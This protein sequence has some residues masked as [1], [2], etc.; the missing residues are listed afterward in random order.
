MDILAYGGI[1]RSVNVRNFKDDIAVLKLDTMLEMVEMT[2]ELHKFEADSKVITEGVD[3]IDLDLLYMEAEEKTSKQRKSILDSAYD[4][5]KNLFHKI[6][7]MFRSL[8]GVKKDVPPSKNIVVPDRY[9]ADKNIIKALKSMVAGIP[10][11]I[12]SHKVLASAALAIG[13]A[14]GTIIAIVKSKKA[15]DAKVMKASQVQAEVIQPLSEINKSLE[16]FNDELMK[17][18]VDIIDKDGSVIDSNKQEVKVKTEKPNESNED[19]KP[20]EEKPTTESVEGVGDIGKYLKMTA[21][22]L[23]S[24]ITSKLTFLLTKIKGILDYINGVFLKVTGSDAS[25]YNGDDESPEKE[26]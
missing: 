25:E 18:D 20:S 19:N 7:E 6:G 3:D 17:V 11:N 24:F 22:Q 21:S 12:K 26:K 5:I 9:G 14:S 16:T 23:L 13:A 8:A 2:E 4:F 10:H 1:L 15:N